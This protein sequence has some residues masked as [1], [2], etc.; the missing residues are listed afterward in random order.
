AV[1]LDDR[2]RR[3]PARRG[4]AGPRQPGRAQM[5]RR[6]A[7]VLR[8]PHRGGDCRRARRVGE[9]GAARLGFRAGVAPARAGPRA[10][11]GRAVSDERWRRLEAIYHEARARP[12]EVREAY[13]DDACRGDD[14][15]RGEVASLLA[16][17]DA[18]LLDEM[19]S[20]AAQLLTDAAAP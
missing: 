9:D 8:R 18:G 6:R 12:A 16:Q 20:S 7:E 19:A 4:A 1:R 3:H 5:P 17:S 13:L 14:G 11:G 10:A 2:S 15:L